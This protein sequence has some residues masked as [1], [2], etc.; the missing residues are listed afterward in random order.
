MNH[1]CLGCRAFLGKANLRRINCPQIG[2]E[3]TTWGCQHILGAH[4]ERAL[5]LIEAAKAKVAEGEL[6]ENKSR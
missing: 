3:I 4:P 5:R 1:P 2:Q 6:T